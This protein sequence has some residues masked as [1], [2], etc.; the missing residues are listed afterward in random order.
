MAR[1]F[2]KLL[3][4]IFLLQTSLNARDINLNTLTQDIENTD[5]HLFVW[6]HKT[7]CGYCENMREF[8]LLNETM[9]AFIEKYFIFIHINI[10]EKDNV[11]YKDFRGDGKE[12]AS[13]IGYNLYP[14][15]FFFNSK[16]E[17]VFEEI[18]YLDTNK[19]ANETRFYKILNFIQSKAYKDLELH[20]YI[21]IT[22]E[23][24]DD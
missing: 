7:D 13:Y 16:K 3:C 17:L 10:N 14:S 8:T 24:L 2:M 1:F 12:F 23:V 6:F 11:I 20:E 15:S 18:G 4:L 9:K 19:V 21:F 22:K 5:K